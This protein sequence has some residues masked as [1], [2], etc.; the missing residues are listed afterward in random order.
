MKSCIN[1]NINGVLIPI[2]TSMMYYKGNTEYTSISDVEPP[3]SLV[4][5]LKK[6]SFPLPVA[7]GIGIGMNKYISK[8]RT[9]T[10]IVVKSYNILLRVGKSEDEG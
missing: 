9:T 7:V 4:V 8:V 5:A 6:V 1:Y 10:I 2:E 3:T